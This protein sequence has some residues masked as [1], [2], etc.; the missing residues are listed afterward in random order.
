MDV[1][2]QSNTVVLPLRDPSSERP[3]LNNNHKLDA[4]YYFT[5]KQPSAQRPPLEPDQRPPI[6]WKLPTIT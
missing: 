3:P 5:Y 1:D 2:V 6:M 4:P